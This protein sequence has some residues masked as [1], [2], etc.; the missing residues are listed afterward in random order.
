MME[1][2]ILD[3]SEFPD[4]YHLDFKNTKSEF[5]DMCHKWMKLYER[6]EKFNLFFDTKHLKRVSITTVFSFPR[7]IRIHELSY[8]STLTKRSSIFMIQNYCI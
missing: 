1:S 2:V 5:N 3:D 4:V 7:F 8:K 6:G